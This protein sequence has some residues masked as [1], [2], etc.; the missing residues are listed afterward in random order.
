MPSFDKWLF[1]TATIVPDTAAYTAGDSIGGALTFDVSGSASG[2]GLINTLL[3]ADNEGIGA[4]GA[5]WLFK[6]DLVTP[7]ADQAA[8]AVGYADFANLITILTLPSFVSISSMKVALLT[9]IND[10]FYVTTGKIIG[11]YVPSGTPDWAAAKSIT[12][13]LGILTQ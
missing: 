8:F 5:L 4:A 1:P 11:Y 10:A 13:R 2:G 3:V 6:Q 7:I 9:D 12:V